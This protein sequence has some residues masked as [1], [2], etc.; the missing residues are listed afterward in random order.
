MI[1]AYV[2]GIALGDGNLSNPNGRAYRLRVTCDK[3]YPLL[4]NYIASSLKKLFPKNKIGTIHRKGCTD[5]SLYSNRLPKLLGWKPENGPKDKQNI[6][7]P[8]WIKKEIGPTK[9]CLRGLFQTDGSVYKDRGY[10]MA[11]FVNNSAKLINDVCEMIKKIKH[12]PNIQVIKKENGK[13]KHTV[14][15]SINSQNFIKEIGLWKK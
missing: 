5:I 4:K 7:V 12:T 11:N 3:R 2:V 8:D 14:R 6:G 13:T 1:L 15:V 9:Q 10:L